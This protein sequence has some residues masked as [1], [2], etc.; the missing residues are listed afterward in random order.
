MAQ[1][2]PCDICGAEAAIQMLT[3]LEDGTVI[4]LGAAC[5][6][7]FYGQSAL[8]TMQAGE[9]KGPSSKCQACRRMHEQ[10]TTPVAQLGADPAETTP[11]EQPSTVV[12]EV[13]ETS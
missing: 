2:L 3:N 12:N 11:L 9:H 13:A 8:I 6:P 5:L 4:T 7:H 1:Q 10:M